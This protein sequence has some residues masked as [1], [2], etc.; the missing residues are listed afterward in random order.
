[1][2]TAL[3]DIIA[4]L[5]KAPEVTVLSA[6]IDIQEQLHYLP[7]ESIPA[8]AELTGVSV[9]D[10]Y[11]VATFYTHFRFSPPGEHVIEAC[12]GPSCHLR[13]ASEVM[14]AAEKAVGATFDSDTPDGKFTLRKLSC[15]G[16]CGHGPV[17]VLDH[18][19]RGN[20]G[21]A[22]VTAFVEQARKSGDS[23]H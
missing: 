10:V 6:L 3:A 9:N 20:A 18:K 22:D 23:H 5:K 21:P 8:V 1:M 13:G 15:A 11:T 2:A 19:M 16:A 4:A 17:V 14:A 7:P 12:W